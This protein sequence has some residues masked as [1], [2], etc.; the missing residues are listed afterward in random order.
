M[1]FPDDDGLPLWVFILVILLTA[2][3][4]AVVLFVVW[5]KYI[6]RKSVPKPAM[7]S[8]PESPVRKISIRK[9]Q[10]IRASCNMSL[11]GSRFGGASFGQSQH[12]S[13]QWPETPYLDGNKN[14]VQKLGYHY[15]ARSVPSLEDHPATTPRRSWSDVI[16][17]QSR[18][19]LPSDEESIRTSYISFPVDLPKLSIMLAKPDLSN[20][21]RQGLD[22]PM[23]PPPITA[24]TFPR[25][26]KLAAS[27][28]SRPRLPSKQV[29]V[30][31]VQP[32]YRISRYREEL[33]SICSRRQRD[34]RIIDG[35]FPSSR[36]PSPGYR[37]SATTSSSFLQAWSNVYRDWLVVS[38]GPSSSEPA[39]P[40]SCHID[41]VSIA[42]SASKS[43]DDSHCDVSLPSSTPMLS[44][45]A[46]S[47]VS[48][49]HSCGTTREW[50]KSV[51]KPL[52]CMMEERSWL[53]EN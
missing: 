11:T 42:E 2:G 6:R 4:I 25:T 9:G 8:V 41:S 32:K 33:N 10:I 50:R 40:T 7:L 1:R 22:S 24:I 48:S 18:V 52:S 45:K 3:T 17:R 53:V 27:S 36:S 49:T 47:A 13:P 37:F 31:P 39:K 46:M 20:T 21:D 26:P 23:L 30:P 43:M 15:S 35:C 5:R 51:G 44:T 29:S 16:R 38:E 19:G 14:D 34:S 28:Y 12:L